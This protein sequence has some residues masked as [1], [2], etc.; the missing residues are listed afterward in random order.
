MARQ[1]YSRARPPTPEVVTQESL[2][3]AAADRVGRIRR[4]RIAIHLHLSKLRP[5]NRQEAHLRIAGR[6]LDPLVQVYRAQVF[7]L[8]NADIVLLCK[9]ARP[10][11]LDRLVFRLRGLFAADPLTYGDSGD[12][13]DQFCD[14]YDLTTDYDAFMALARRLDDE[15]RRRDRERQVTAL[16]PIQPRELHDIL[17]K[18]D[19]FDLAPLVRRQ[20]ALR[21]GERQNPGTAFQEVFVAIAELQSALS[22]HVDLLGNRWLFQHL[23]QTLDRRVLKVVMES[24]LQRMPPTLSLNLN[25]A[26]I[27][28]R[29][30]RHFVDAMAARG[31]GVMVEVQTVDVFA[32]LGRFCYA[33]DTLQAMGHKILID[34]VTALTLQFADIAQYGADLVKLFWSP[35]FL[36]R[37]AGLDLNETAARL[38]IERIVLGR[39]DS[40]AAIRW[41]L[42]AGIQCFQG[43]YVDAMQAA[44]AMATCS[45]SRHCTLAQCTARHGAMAGPLRQACRNH[46]VLD[47]LPRLRA[48]APRNGA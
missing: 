45:E 33:R 6:M 22:P 5:H 15:V 12:G 44:M 27:H 31:V 46:R 29:E 8:S 34:G 19:D 26:T 1:E 38:G 37:H 42:D 28:T 9:D 48:Q 21:L 39:C 30:F 13:R 10:A 43:R 25:V 36:D 18:L 4:G 41:G 23:S 32:D 40:E 20:S 16:R 17:G 7:F 35:D 3:L 14:W 24:S 2:L 11:D 47:I